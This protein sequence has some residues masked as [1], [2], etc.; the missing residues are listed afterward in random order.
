MGPAPSGA[1]GPGPRPRCSAAS[2]A[3]GGAPRSRCA[4]SVGSGLELISGSVQR[5]PDPL[6]RPMASTPVPITLISGTSTVCSLLRTPRRHRNGSASLPG[7]RTGSGTRAGQDHL[8]RPGA[9]HVKLGSGGPMGAIR[10]RL[11]NW[12]VEVW[13]LPTKGRR[14]GLA[15][16]VVGGAVSGRGS[17]PVGPPGAEDRL[18]PCSAAPPGR[19][20]R[21]RE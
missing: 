6:G 20:C 3:M 1:G 17:R 21:N 16:A 12:K 7:N 13:D 11:E 14:S 10:E 19:P 5:S 15:R 9:S 2:C 8:P 18:R 4:A